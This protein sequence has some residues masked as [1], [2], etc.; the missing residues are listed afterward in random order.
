[1]VIQTPVVH[2][3]S[4]PDSFQPTSLSCIDTDVQALQLCVLNVTA[5]LWTQHT[6]SKGFKPK[7]TRKYSE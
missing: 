4:S 2:T 5:Q 3:F 1:M 7:V 6:D